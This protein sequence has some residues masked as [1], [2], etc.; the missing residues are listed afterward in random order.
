MNRI[1]LGFVAAITIA[2]GVL[3]LDAGWANAVATSGVKA[4]LHS[5]SW[6][7]GLLIILGFGVMFQNRIVLFI[8]AAVYGI[9]GLLLAVG[10]PFWVPF[11]WSLF[12]VFAGVILLLPAVACCLA[13][14]NIRVK[15]REASN[16]DH[17]KIG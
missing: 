14:K 7:G 2:L 16:N 6:L 15:N 4:N 1:A 17:Q 8:T 5:V 12:N 11:P 10:S 9:V 13:L 3:A